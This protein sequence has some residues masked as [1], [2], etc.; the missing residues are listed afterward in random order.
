MIPRMRGRVGRSRPSSRPAPGMWFSPI[1]CC[2]MRSA[3]VSQAT[4][5]Q[6]RRPPAL[7]R[8]STIPPADPWWSATARARFG[9]SFVNVDTLEAL[10]AP[11]PD[12]LEPQLLARSEWSWDEL[13]PSL[14]KGATRQRIGVSGD[15]D[16]V[17]LYGLKLPTPIYTRTGVPTLMALQVTSNRLDSASRVRRPIALLQVTDLGLHARVGAEEGVVWVTGARD[18]KP[19][20]G[21]SIE[22]HDAKGRVVA[23]ARTDSAGLARL[24]G[25][26]TPA[27][28]RGERRRDREPWLPG[29]R[30]R[31]GWD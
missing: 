8:R 12:S 31:R 21:V 17:R 28:D 15:R 13:W 19:R 25:F 5:S 4:Q 20:A 6:R 23:R 16:R 10:F 18:G 9:L 24:T 14:L 29:V 22:L 11:V 3:S 7:P 1:R 30:K 26:G 27:R 2:A